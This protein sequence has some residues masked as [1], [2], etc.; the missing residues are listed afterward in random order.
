MS[1]LFQPVQVATGSSDSESRLVFDD[2]FLVA[3]LV[4]LCAQHGDQAGRW[5]LEAGFGRVEHANPP[6]FADLDVAQ[7]WIE[8]QLASAED[9]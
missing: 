1:L 4:Q 2:G 5:F 9:V 8:R 7:D 3:I 6:T